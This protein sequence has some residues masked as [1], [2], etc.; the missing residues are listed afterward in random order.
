[1]Q[2]KLNKLLSWIVPE[3]GGAFRDSDQIGY[4]T[5]VRFYFVGHKPVNL[6]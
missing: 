4:V 3:S 2:L 6:S 1:M 5:P